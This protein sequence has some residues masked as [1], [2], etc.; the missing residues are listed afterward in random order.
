MAG[1][2]AHVAIVVSIILLAGAHAFSQIQTTGRIAGTVKDEQGAVIASAEVV[3]ENPATA[4]NRSLVTDSSGSYSIPQLCPGY[5]DIN[6]RAHGFT[7][8]VFHTVAEGLG[9][10]T[11]VNV[12]LQIAQSNIEVTVNHVPPPV[13]S[14]GVPW[15]TSS[16]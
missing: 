11:T 14:D 12:T 15:K 8:A 9:E 3:I 16:N 4:D 2:S 6:V 13:R 7:P 5:Y 10:S 1:R